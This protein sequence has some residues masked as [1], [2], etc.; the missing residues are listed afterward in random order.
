MKKRNI[1]YGYK[2]ENG[3]V[4]IHP[5]ESQIC[6]RI[7][8]AYL[9]GLSLLKIADQLNS[10]CIEYMPSIIG[11]NKARLKRMIEDVR[12]IGNNQYPAI[13]DQT[14]F[15]NIQRTKTDRNTQK[16]TDRQSENFQLTAPVICPKCGNK[17]KRHHDNRKK[18]KRQWVCTNDSCRIRIDKSDEDIITD[19]TGILNEI[20]L[21]PSLIAIS[22][23]PAQEMNTEIMR[24]QNEIN[25]SIEHRESDKQ[26]TQKMILQCASLKYKS[27][28]SIKYL[29]ERLKKIY[30][31]ASP[32]TCFSTDLFNETVKNIL[33]Y[34]DG[35]VGITLINNQHIRKDQ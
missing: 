11:W 33:I 18:C 13:I 14:T 1:L 7:F 31:C 22:E 26:K 15:D 8:D 19:I 20:I 35:T 34:A 6:R 32:L 2:C 30:G 25:R 9:N 4:A 23:N 10:E 21:N 17:M 27:I 5:Q 12:Y 24:L 28:D 3:V 16:N 29:S